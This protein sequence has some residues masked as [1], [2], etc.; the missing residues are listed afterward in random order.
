MNIAETRERLRDRY[1]KWYT[2]KTA[3]EQDYLQMLHD[4]KYSWWEREKDCQEWCSKEGTFIPMSDTKT[5]KIMRAWF[6]EWRENV[7]R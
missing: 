2:Q 4:A 1:I 5:L 7:T 6:K 3:N